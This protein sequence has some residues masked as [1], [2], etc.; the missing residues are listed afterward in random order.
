MVEG[1]SLLDAV[2]GKVDLSDAIRVRIGDL[3]ALRQISVLLFAQ[4]KF[5]Y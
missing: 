3:F 5:A 2:E 4:N 1:E